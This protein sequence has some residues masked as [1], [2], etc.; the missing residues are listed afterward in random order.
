MNLMKANLLGCVSDSWS[1]T[2]SIRDLHQDLEGQ[3]RIVNAGCR[4]G[5][6]FF[7]LRMTSLSCQAEKK[8][9]GGGGKAVP[10]QYE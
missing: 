5:N 4:T 2:K 8:R 6:L 3:R 1:W 7:C 10:E 9:N